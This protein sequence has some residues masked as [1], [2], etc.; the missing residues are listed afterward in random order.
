MLW[1]MINSHSAIPKFFSNVTDENKEFV[2]ATDKR[3]YVLRSELIIF[4]AFSISHYKTIVLFQFS[5][6]LI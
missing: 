6:N 5:F 3:I 4:L 1:N 2:S